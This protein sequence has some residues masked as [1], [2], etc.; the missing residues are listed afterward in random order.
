MV[1][2]YPYIF[3]SAVGK[4]VKPCSN[5]FIHTFFHSIDKSGVKDFLRQVIVNLMSRRVFTLFMWIFR[6]VAAPAV[7]LN[8]AILK[9]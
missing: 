5:L 9:I 8:Y 3:V 1:K 4:W 7:L 2:N 6:I